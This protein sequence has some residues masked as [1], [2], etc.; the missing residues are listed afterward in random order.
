MRELI[1]CFLVLA[2]AVCSCGDNNDERDESD[3]LGREL[4]DIPP[5]TKGTWYRAKVETT[6]QWQLV[7]TL[8]TSYNVAVYDIDL[9][10][11]PAATIAALQAAGRRV[12]CYFSAGSS[13]DWRDD[14]DK[15]AA[16][17]MGNKLDE[18]EGERWL[19]IRSQSVLSIMQARLDLAVSKGCDGVEPDNMDAA[20]NDSGFDLTGADQVDYNRRIANEAHRRGLTVAL[21]NAGDWT[22]YLVAYFDL[23]LNEQC[24]EW[25]EC[26]QL[27]AFLDAGKPIFNAEY[28]ESEDLAAKRSQTLCPVARGENI[29]TLILPLDLDDSFRVSCD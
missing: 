1:A 4:A 23:S 17:D 24:H 27:K 3:D 8:N 25:D 7:G 5:L 6:W 2:A 18:W 10:N 15:F 9:F 21:K 29:R 13:E 16:A 20:A 14:F 26:D 19:D 12:I 28:E 11:T 22:S